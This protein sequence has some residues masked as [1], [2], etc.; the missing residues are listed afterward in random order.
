MLSQTKIQAEK[1]LIKLLRRIVTFPL[2]AIIS[3][4]F[5]HYIYR[6]Y[7]LSYYTFIHIEQINATENV[8][9]LLLISGCFYWICVRCLKQATI[10][11]QA[12]QIIQHHVVITILIPLIINI[13]KVILLLALFN[14]ITPYL[15]LS[16]ELAES[17][18]K[19]SSILIISALAW[20]LIKSTNIVEQ[21]ILHRYK[22]ENKKDLA[23]RKIYTQ[24]VI[25]ATATRFKIDI[26]VYIFRAA[27]S[28]LFSAL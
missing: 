27:K 7:V 28:F 25:I 24:I 10:F 14:A 6:H 15:E 8:G 18:E 16:S 11:I 12:S 5:L 22:A 17:L 4:F 2:L 9:F 13:T 19:L 23:A 20:L 26:W 21:L 1:G 3:I